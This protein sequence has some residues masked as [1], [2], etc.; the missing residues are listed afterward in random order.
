M[1]HRERDASKVGLVSAV[2]RLFAAGIVLFDVQFLTEHLKSL[3]AYEIS[4]ARYLELGANAAQRAVQL[5][6]RDIFAS[7]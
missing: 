3:G 4:R 1:F 2:Q 5:N 7:G 6:N